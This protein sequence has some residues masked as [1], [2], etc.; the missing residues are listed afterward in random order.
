M[1]KE[2]LMAIKKL[3]LSETKRIP[4]IQEKKKWLVDFFQKAGFEI[5]EEAD[6]STDLCFCLGGD[7]SLLAT[8]RNMGE[9]RYDVPICGIHCSKGLGF[10]HTLSFPDDEKE[11]MIWA[12]HI[13]ESIQKGQ[14]SIEQRWGLQGASYENLRSK[15]K[16]SSFWALNDLVL[17]KGTLSRMISLKLHVDGSLVFQKMRGDGFIIASSTGSTAYS[18]AAGGPIV[19]PS[20]ESIIVTPISPHEIAQR[21]L[22]LSSYSEI[23]IEVLEGAP[24]FLTED[25]QT[26]FEMR[27]GEVVR[28]QKAEQAIQW[29]VPN[30][31]ELGIKNYY[32]L[33]R[34]KLGFFGGERIHAQ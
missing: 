2:F 31:P 5:Q 17:S 23:E 11:R 7:G 10:L 32:E 12:E 13:V 28:V 15:S 27:A 21:P 14:F 19:A 8:L 33:L 25:G 29:W 24:C 22:V 1:M 30:N 3:F 16:K 6:S 34:G 9:M 18:F 26:G 20:L 4:E